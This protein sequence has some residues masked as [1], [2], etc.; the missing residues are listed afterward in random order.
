MLVAGDQRHGSLAFVRGLRDGGLVPY[1]AVRTGAAYARRSRSVAAAVTVPSAADQP[2]EFVDALA[3]AAAQFEVDAVLP[4]TEAS[5][6][7]LSRREW[8][9]AVRIGLPDR[10]IVELA[11]DKQRVL[12]LA[13]DAGLATPASIVGPPAALARHADSLRYPA[14]LKPPRTRLE[15]ADSGT[16]SDTRLGFYQARRVQDATE[17]RAQLD[18]LPEADWVVQPFLDGQLSAIAGVAWKG[19]LQ[20]AVHQ[21]SHRIWPPDVGYSSYAQTV[22]RDRELESRVAKLIGLIGWS[23]LFQA[24]LLRTVDQRRLLIDFNPRAYGSLAL[25]VGAGA[26]LPALWA[27]D[28][29]GIDPPPAGYRAGVRYRMEHNDLRA[30]FKT[31]RDGHPLAALTALS[32]HPRTVH[33]IVRLRDPGPVLTAVGKLVTLRQRDGQ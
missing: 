13:E 7:A 31:L 15:V 33:A 1:L 18:E 20:C 4:V 6:I 10:E 22:A 11:T 30:I 8:P 21:V 25:A 26:N 16:G 29:L 17:L 14:I 19:E 9:L 23:G 32:P 28:V 5:L 3:R 12:A 27:S 24:Q 2:E